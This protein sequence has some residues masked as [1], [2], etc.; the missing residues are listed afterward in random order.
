MA[1]DAMLGSA[2]VQT[3][4]D[5]GSGMEAAGRGGEGGRLAVESH[6][7]EEKVA[8]ARAALERGESGAAQRLEA[9]EEELERA[10]EAVLDAEC[11]G[12]AGFGDGGSGESS[13]DSEGG[14]G[15]FDGINDDPSEEAFLAASTRKA[16]G[17]SGGVGVSGGGGGR[18]DD[19]AAGFV[20]ADGGGVGDE[21]DDDDVDPEAAGRMSSSSGVE[22]ISVAAAATTANDGKPR[23][24]NS[25]RSGNGEN[26]WAEAGSS[27]SSSSSRDVENGGGRPEQDP[28][29]G[30]GR[31]AKRRKTEGHEQQGESKSAPANFSRVDPSLPRAELEKRFPLFLEAESCTVEVEAGQMLYLPAGWFHEVSSVASEHGHM[32][33]NYWFHPP[34]SFDSSSSPYE[35]SFWQRDWE[36][37]Q[38]EGGG[39][40][41]AEEA[42]Q[43]E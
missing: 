19:L 30:E 42:E 17:A 33:F 26:G 24:A 39:L 2:T 16:R 3:P 28:A 1:S 22:V 32:A 31:T 23:G 29:A 43:K 5:P 12:G 8:A 37:R 13:S 38:E 40:G 27:S 7:S 18:S 4:G 6:K 10:L 34:D 41:A 15:F 9:A 25:R 20:G 21:D 35:S 14:P 36:T 11:A